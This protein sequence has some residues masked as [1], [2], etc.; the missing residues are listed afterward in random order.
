MWL[1]LSFD[2]SFFRR[3]HTHHRYSENT[4]I[5]QDYN[6]K[7]IS[8]K[9]PQLKSPWNNKKDQSTSLFILLFLLVLVWF[10]LSLL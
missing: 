7:S 6:T 10:L 8:T 3:L 4:V 5:T 1:V 2:H 9:L